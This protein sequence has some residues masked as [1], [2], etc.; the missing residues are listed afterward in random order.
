MDD[1][2]M[3]TVTK[4][5]ENI[6]NI[7]N[8]TN[9]TLI[10]QGDQGAVFKISASHCVKIYIRNEFT[11][12]EYSSYQAAKSSSLV[13]KIYGKGAN[14]IIMDFLRGPSLE[15]YLQGRGTMPNWITKQIILVLKEMKRLHFTKIDSFLRHIFIDKNHK[16]KIIDLVNA[17]TVRDS[18]PFRLFGDL[19]RLGLLNAFLQQSQKLASELY[20]EWQKSPQ[21]FSFISK[22]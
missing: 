6:M 20:Q 15:R 14:Y 16:I 2:R 5:S 11:A 19:K 4:S 3:I 7:Y 12:R 8:P 22:Q 18:F 9:Y 1:F 10:G 21:F 17:Y 13:A